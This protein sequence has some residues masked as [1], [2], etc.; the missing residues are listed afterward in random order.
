MTGS[1]LEYAAIDVQMDRFVRPE[2]LDLHTDT[3]VRTDRFIKIATVKIDGEAHFNS[4]CLTVRDSIAQSGIK[5]KWFSG[6]ETNYKK[7]Q[8]PTRKRLIRIRGQTSDRSP[9]IGGTTYVVFE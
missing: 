7:K 5:V 4:F 8:P 6:T 3:Q 9:E 1:I 2:T